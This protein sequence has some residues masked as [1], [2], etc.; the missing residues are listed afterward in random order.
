MKILCILC[1]DPFLDSDGANYAIRANLRLL[2]QQ[3]DVEVTGFGSTFDRPMVGSYRSCGSLGVAVNSKV[4]FLLSLLIGK[5]YTVTKYGSPAAQAKLALILAKE[6]IDC[7]WFEQTQSAFVATESG[8]LPAH[9]PMFSVLRPHNI[10]SNVIR[11]AI[12][13]RV[14]FA[15][16]LL[17]LEARL[18][19]RAERRVF[20]YVDFI[21]AI[22]DTDIDTIR[23]ISADAARK[24]VLLPVAADRMHKE[25]SPEK[26]NIRNSLLFIGNCVWGANRR[27]LEWV[28]DVLAPYMQE[29]CPEFEI[30]LVG[31]GT[32]TIRSDSIL[33]NTKLLGYVNDIEAEYS[34][35]ICAIAPVR[36]G[37][38]VNIKVI[39]SLTRG[40][41]V[42]G[43][44]FAK[45]GVVSE[46]YLVAETPDE[47]VAS[48]RHLSEMLNMPG[49][50]TNDAFKFLFRSENDA[51]RAI[52]NI[53]S[54]RASFVNGE[55]P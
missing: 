42:V 29:H 34:R 9:R 12:N 36:D 51:L 17:A 26:V 25:L 28:I 41:P 31:K 11:G 2:S 35:A 10:E 52:E 50:L 6:S 53:F 45:R 49:R 39:E 15:G 44:N 30:R 16:L 7:L 24:L 5:P 21:A 13:T 27:A 22:S 33:S 3:H 40:V 54:H 38:G 32:D 37:G 4:G 8:V 46:A 1:R 20:R 19:A 55:I 43:S 48:I 47:Y 14:P 18:L 23:A